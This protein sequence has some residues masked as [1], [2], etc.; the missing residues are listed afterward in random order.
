MK[1]KIDL[2]NGMPVEIPELDETGE[3]ERERL[4]ALAFQEYQDT[5]ALNSE[6]LQEANADFL[7]TAK[8][9]LIKSDKA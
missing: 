9:H 7:K 6:R 5:G 4:A 8:G 2:I 3:R 1:K